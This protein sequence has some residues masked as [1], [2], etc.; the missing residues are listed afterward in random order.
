[1]TRGQARGIEHAFLEIEIPGAVLLRHQAALQ[2]VGEPRHDALEVGEL[3][4]EIVAQPRQLLGVAEVL[5]RDLLVELVGDRRGR[6]PRSRA[7]RR[8]AAAATA[9]RRRAAPRPPCRRA[10]R[11]YRSAGRPSRRRRSRPRRPAAPR[12]PTAGF[13]APRLRASPRARRNRARPPASS[14]SSDWSGSSP[15]SS[16]MSRAAMMSRDMRAKAAWSWM[17]SVRWSRWRRG[18]L[19]DPGAPQVDQRL[20][21]PRAARSPVSLSRTMSA[22]ASSSGASLSVAPGA[23]A[24]FLDSGRRAWR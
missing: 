20:A 1:M 15:S 14:F 19:L 13:P 21:L 6:N 18:L 9:P 4:V 24:F 3:L 5:G 2:A 23:A 17:R 10:C 11:R 8:E 7:R 16:A 22:T 12:S